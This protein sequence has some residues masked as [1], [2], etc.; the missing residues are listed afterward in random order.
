MQTPARGNIPVIL[1]LLVNCDQLTL[2]SLPAKLWTSYDKDVQMGFGF[3]HFYQSLHEGLSNCQ[4]GQI[5]GQF[6]TL[7][8]FLVEAV[9]RSTC[10]PGG[11]S[12]LQ[13]T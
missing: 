3:P 1:D 8:V 6:C 5:V 11:W 12:Q 9:K 10:Q 2:W 7:N 4:G 13:V